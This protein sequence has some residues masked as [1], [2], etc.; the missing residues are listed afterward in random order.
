MVI[1]QKC[2]QVVFSMHEFSFSSITV[3]WKMMEKAGFNKQKDRLVFVK[4][5]N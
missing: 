4:K 2:L 3:L 1:S 5:R